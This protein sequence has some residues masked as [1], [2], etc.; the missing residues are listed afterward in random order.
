[1]KNKPIKILHIGNIANNAYLNAKI[2]NQHGLINHVL[3]YD[4]YH[5][6]GC[7]EWEDGV[8]EGGYGSDFAPNWRKARVK[9]F[10][11]PKWFIQG[12][13][14]LS[15]NYLMAINK[16][17][18][19]KGY[20][21]N[22]LIQL[23]KYKYIYSLI[24]SARDL[25]NQFYVAIN[26]ILLSFRQWIN[27]C[28]NQAY[29][30]TQLFHNS[31]LQTNI[32]GYA[33]KF[34]TLKQ[35]YQLSSAMYSRVIY[36]P[37]KTTVQYTLFRRTNRTTNEA[38][39]TSIFEQFQELHSVP[40]EYSAE[41]RKHIGMYQFLHPKLKSL[42]DDY[43]LVVGYGL[44]G[45]FPLLAN[46]RP[47]FC[48][49]HGTIRSLPFENS[50]NGLLCK[51]TYSKA[52][53][54]FITNCDNIYSVKK[55]NLSNFQFIPHPI[56]ETLVKT[57]FDLRKQLEEQ[58]GTNFILFHPSRHH[59][60]NERDP[61]MEKGNDFLIK[62]F[63]NFVHHTNN[64]ALAIFVDWGVHVDKSKALIEELGISNNVIWI[65]P[66]PNM[67]MTNYIHASDV[68]A[69]QFY[70][71]AFGSTMPKALLN[72]KPCLIYLNESQHQWCLDEMPPILNASTAF[73]IF[74]HLKA[75]YE[76]PELKIKIGKASKAWYDA[77]HS[78]KVIAEI[79][80]DV[81]NKH[82]KNRLTA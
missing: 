26:K 25:G 20:C 48:F 11:R 58:T 1:M 61:N 27:R 41:F 31:L 53:S 52:N 13:L 4:Y 57:K 50:I 3:C 29:I 22:Q 64:K 7:P 54:V 80:L 38:N 17:H 44:D 79:F 2:L 42:L 69:D 15:M 6:M 72:S 66:Q 68:I 81:I 70:L 12:P 73:G 24:R 63:A 19:L 67:S 51:L 76:D 9:Q 71:G 55:L 28:L 77:Y 39:H 34:S 78:N 45:L 40:Q 16:Q 37:I 21:I 43:D 36:R 8:F 5:I 82:V 75:I 14:I 60:S 56:N 65:R 33:K 10:K 23:R 49:E 35:T 47:Y 18:R 59:W 32:A 46:K 74:K 30:R 62:G